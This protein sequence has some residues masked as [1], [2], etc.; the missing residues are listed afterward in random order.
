ML[1][2]PFLWIHS[3]PSLHSLITE[4]SS[5][6]SLHLSHTQ[7]YSQLDTSQICADPFIARVNLEN[8]QSLHRDEFPVDS[9]DRKLHSLYFVVELL[10]STY[11]SAIGEAFCF[12]EKKEKNYIQDLYFVLLYN[13]IEQQQWF[14]QMLS[15]SYSCTVFLVDRRAWWWA[16]DGV[17]AGDYQSHPGHQILRT[18][19]EW[20]WTRRLSTDW[21]ALDDQIL[22]N[23]GWS[24]FDQMWA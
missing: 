16:S 20:T 15:T 24:Y 23:S 22:I 7:T 17:W 1:P 6:L 8:N 14:A 4:T 13:A 18:R 3:L 2:H 5:S 11:I 21:S 19:D 10:H 12:E 9:C